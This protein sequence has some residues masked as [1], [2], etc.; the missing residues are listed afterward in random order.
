MKPPKTL[1]A[2]LHE[3]GFELVTHEVPWETPRLASPFQLW[4]CD[5]KSSPV[6][7]DTQPRVEPSKGGGEREGESRLIMCCSCTETGALR[8]GR[9]VHM[10]RDMSRDTTGE[11]KGKYRKRSPTSARALTTAC[12]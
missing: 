1:S 11:G 7:F 8:R 4:R 10:S 3:H 5:N 12:L 6:G 9:S 2:V